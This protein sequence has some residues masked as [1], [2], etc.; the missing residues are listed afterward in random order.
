MAAADGS[1]LGE[2]A[3]GKE[4]GG[5]HTHTGVAGMGKENHKERDKGTGR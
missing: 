2:R 1:V 4:G 3:G 5:G